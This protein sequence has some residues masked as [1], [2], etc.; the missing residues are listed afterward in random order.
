MLK[1]EIGRL[2]GAYQAKTGKPLTYRD[3]SSE[4]RIAESTLSRL[5][6]GHTTRIDFETVEKLL[7]F[8]SKKLEIT[9]DTHNLLSWDGQGLT[10][11]DEAT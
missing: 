5:G 1:W 7:L 11:R 3:I 10:D 8:F 2:M 4:T 6:N 9:L